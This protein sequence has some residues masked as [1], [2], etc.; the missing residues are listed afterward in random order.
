L[1]NHFGELAEKAGWEVLLCWDQTM[2][3]PFS[4]IGD[5]VRNYLKHIAKIPEHALPKAI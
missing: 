1:Y 2:P 5:S 3:F 4:E